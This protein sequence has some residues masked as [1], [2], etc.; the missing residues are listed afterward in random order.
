[1]SKWTPGPWVVCNSSW[2]H[3]PFA[4]QEE[5][6]QW[7]HLNCVAGDMW[8]SVVPLNGFQPLHAEAHAMAELLHRLADDLEDGHWSETKAEI[9]ALLAR[10][11]ADK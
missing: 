9:L 10:L 1:M 2:A 5:A 3:G 11:E 7:R 6:E 4:T 8:P